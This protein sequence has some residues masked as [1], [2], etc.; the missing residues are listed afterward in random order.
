MIKPDQKI[1]GQEVPLDMIASKDVLEKLM[2]VTKNQTNHNINLVKLDGD[3]P[4]EK[5]L[6]TGKFHQG[7]K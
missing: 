6:E 1:E 5:L 7:K 4:D 3:C 2:D